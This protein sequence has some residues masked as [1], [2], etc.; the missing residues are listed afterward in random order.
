M[1]EDMR[2]L[3]ALGA[4]AVVFGQDSEIVNNAEVL[5]DDVFLCRSGGE[6][7]KPSNR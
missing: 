6:N 1:E 4:V 7:C 2:E 5:I 3:F